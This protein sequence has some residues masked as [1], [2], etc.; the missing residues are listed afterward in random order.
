M[1]WLLT[2]QNRTASEDRRDRRRRRVP[3]ASARGS[4]ATSSVSIGIYFTVRPLGAA[5]AVGA[6]EGVGL[7][8]A[9]GEDD[10][11]PVSGCG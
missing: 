2:R 6:G 5:G 10:V 1:M 3:D 9:A 4:A 11:A 7:L 8:G